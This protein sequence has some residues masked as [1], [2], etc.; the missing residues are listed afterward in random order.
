MDPDTTLTIIRQTRAE[1][2]RR[3]ADGET[4]D[5]SGPLEE[6]MT[7]LAQATED[8]DNWLSRGGFLPAA[9]AEGRA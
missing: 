1:I 6:A 2:R 3:I 5:I 8:L 4:T 7:V 9:W